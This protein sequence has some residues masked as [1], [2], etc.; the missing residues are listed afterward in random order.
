LPGPGGYAVTS[1]SSGEVMQPNDLLP[2]PDILGGPAE[3]AQQAAA[4]TAMPAAGRDILTEY[5]SGAG[6]RL[7]AAATVD[8]VARFETELHAPS[9]DAE[10]PSEMSL[11]LDD[12]AAALR[13]AEAMVAAISS[14]APGVHFAVEQIHDIAMSLRQRDVEPA[15]CDAL[16]TA[17][18]EIGDAVVNN[19]V[20]ATRAQDAAALLREL[21]DR[22]DKLRAVGVAPAPPVQRPN[23][24]DPMPAAEHHADRFDDTSARPVNQVFESRMVIAFMSDDEHAASLLQSTSMLAV[25]PEMEATLGPQEDPAE[26]FEPLAMSVP[27]PIET[28]EPAFDSAETSVADQTAVVKADAEENELAAAVVRAAAEVD[29]PVGDRTEIEAEAAEPTADQP[30]TALDVVEPGAD[31]V[32]LTAEAAQATAEPVEM[33]LA[34]PAI[35]VPDADQMPVPAEKQGESKEEVAAES[36]AAE[37]C[38]DDSPAAANGAELNPPE[39]PAISN[40]TSGETVPLPVNPAQR[41]RDPLAALHSLNEEELIALFS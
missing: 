4:P 24:P 31:R 41:P 19:D 21:M 27:S 17:T 15:L 20:A 34:D 11:A 22:L 5:A 30:E 36:F 12:F 1:V 39:A 18:R 9:T 8:T 37:L 16:E 33:A 28:A 10:A 29:Q 6:D 3:D 13:R 38:A 23:E 25:L 32:E 7:D 35:V 26:L 40:V 14:A 2:T